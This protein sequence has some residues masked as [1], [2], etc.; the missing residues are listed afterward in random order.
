MGENESF[1]TIGDAHLI[2]PCTMV[3]STTRYHHQTK[4]RTYQLTT[5]YIIIPFTNQISES[6]KKLNLMR[7]SSSSTTTTTSSSFSA[8]GRVLFPH[9]KQQGYSFPTQDKGN[10][11]PEWFPLSTTHATQIFDYSSS[12]MNKT[13]QSNLNLWWRCDQ[14]AKICPLLWY[15]LVV[16][17]SASRLSYLR[18]QFL[19]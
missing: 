9:Q 13:L 5:E 3:N 4:V 8:S 12:Y 19:Q 1:N 6:R 16:I 7:S 11:T 10:S 17:S 14:K 15:H 18:L 2:A